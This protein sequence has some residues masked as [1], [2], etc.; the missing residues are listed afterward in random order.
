MADLMIDFASLER[1]RRDL[2]EVEGLLRGPCRGMSE[3]PAD[4]AGHDDLRS[5]LRDF[6]DAWD[7]GIGRLAQFSGAAADALSSIQ[8]TFTELEDELAAAFDQ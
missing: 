3:L 6:G 4:A 2:V 8:K 1:V 7:F 5:R